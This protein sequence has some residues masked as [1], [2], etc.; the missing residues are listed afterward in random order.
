VTRA[1]NTGSVAC[2]DPSALAPGDLMAYA[3]GDAPAN[4]AEHVAQ[5]PFCAAEA[6]ALRRV[7]R[8]LRQ[9]LFRFD[10][11][12]PQILGEYHLDLLSPE[13]RTRI[14]AHELECPHCA[15]ELQTLRSFLDAPLVG[16]DTTPAVMPGFAAAAMGGLRRVVAPLL[17]PPAAPA[18]AGLRGAAEDTV[19]TYQ[20]GDLTITLT[21]TPAARHGRVSLTGLLLS[22]SAGLDEFAGAEVRLIAPGGAPETTEVDDLGNFVFDDLVP[23]AYRVELELED[24]IVIEDLQV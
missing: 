14:A 6:A 12:S 11:P 20:A 1:E 15:A 7:S 21:A 24:R 4:L 23:G 8:R 5:C 19:K 10:C 18:Y 16:Q 17:T 2:I 3:D 22:E 9:A 13:E